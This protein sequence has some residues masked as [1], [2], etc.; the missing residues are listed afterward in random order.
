VNNSLKKL[1]C[2]AVITLLFNF[3][4]AQNVDQQITP[5]EAARIVQMQQQQQQGVRIT[6][7]SS[8]VE[9][10]GRPASQGTVDQNA[11]A[12]QTTIQGLRPR[13]VEPPEENEFQNFV[14]QSV[15]QKLP[16][17]GQSLFAEVPSTFAPIDRVPVSAN[18][19]IGPGDELLIR[20]WG[21]IDI[22]YRAVVDR[23]GNV[24][25]P[26]VGTVSVA[27]LQYQQ[28][29]PYL[30]TAVSK[31]FRNFD[32]SVNIGQLRSIQI[33][34]VGQARHPGSYTV[35]SLSTVVNAVFASG[36]P[37]SKG[38]MR[39]IQLKRENRVVTD[40]DLY[41]LIQHGDKSKDVQLLPGDVIYFAPV[42]PLAAL[43]G[44]VNAP[45]IYELK[46]STPL[47]EA[48]QYA[49]GLTPTAE[50]GKAI[51]ERI[52]ER[53]ERAAAEIPLDPR[54]LTQPLQDGDIVRFIPISPRFDNAVTLRGNVSLPGRYPWHQGMRIRD[55]IPNKET[56]IVRSYWENQNALVK[57]PV[58][59]TDP[60]KPAARSPEQA[61]QPLPPG[62]AQP[63]AELNAPGRT[64]ELPTTSPATG[65]RDISQRVNQERLTTEVKRNAPEINWDYA[66]IQRLNRDDLT[67][68]LIPFNLGKV[69]LEG[70]E[71]NNLDLQPGDVVTIFSQA[72]L[73]VPLAKQS[74]FVKL[75]GEFKAAGI[76][77][78]EP[79]ESLHHLVERAGGLTENAYL[80]GA[81]FT[82]ESTRQDQ[83]KRLNQYITQL[84]Q[85]I[86]RNSLVAA[87]R[88]PS[89]DE[90]AALRAALEN[91]RRLLDV[92]RQTGATGRIVLSLKPTDNSIASLPDFPLEDGDTLIVPY[93]P[94]TVQVIGTVYNQGA[95]F[96]AEGKRLKDYL[97]Q[98][99]GPT[100]DADKSQIFVIRADGSVLANHGRS[101]FSGGISD[102]HMMPGDTIVVPENLNKGAGVRNLKDIAYILGQFGLAAA[103]INVL[104]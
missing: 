7:G 64:G 45:A 28:L 18:Y 50:S 82:R 81:Q 51:V 15:G 10:A 95:F 90:A 84:Q 11:R 54:G 43:F 36:G 29:Q 24:Y 69:V 23:N 12:P 97:R 31:F 88:A 48:I 96:Q 26:R 59:I 83:Q 27:G 57:A 65:E 30:K 17:F 58:Q 62:A 93:A 14:A 70:D 1:A 87:N 98:S 9:N 41:D 101:A 53:K 2:L 78:L 71:S 76:Y 91:Q 21:S 55:L 38:S 25:I 73:Q 35:S 72:D 49:G 13:P 4:I 33:F 92:L 86:E 104:R 61:N 3:A 89:A 8:S 66:V 46:E 103:A 94:S 80:F 16:I 100:R 42:G 79:G 60:T 74:K 68:R 32:L 6:N 67:T 39:H 34:V 20:A 19:A 75:E 85:S 63:G 22:D 102:L 5:E 56:L 77:R 40:F 47:G 44:S 52:N 37:T 99:G